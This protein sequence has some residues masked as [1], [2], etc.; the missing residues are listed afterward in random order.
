MTHFCSWFREIRDDI[1]SAIHSFASW[2]VCSGCSW[3]IYVF[4]QSIKQFLMHSWQITKYC[5]LSSEFLNL[6]WSLA[7]YTWLKSQTHI[8]Q[9]PSQ[10]DLLQYIKFCDNLFLQT[11]F[12]FLLVCAN[13]WIYA[14]HEWI[15]LSVY[16]NIMK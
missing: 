9:E 16:C 13:F 4:L 3:E 8:L 2:A 7:A 1:M 15:D 12:I 6:A 14:F 10:L 11:V 5:L